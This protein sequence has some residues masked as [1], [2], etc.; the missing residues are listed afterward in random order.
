MKSKI[1][2][3]VEHTDQYPAFQKY[4]EAYLERQ[5]IILDLGY[6]IYVL[7]T[8]DK[9]RVKSIKKF[10]LLKQWY[11]DHQDLLKN[12]SPDSLKETVYEKF[13]VSMSYNVDKY[14]DLIIHPEE[15]GFKIDEKCIPKFS[16]EQFYVICNFIRQTALT[17]YEFKKAF[18][19]LTKNKPIYSIITFISST[20]VSWYKPKRDLGFFY[21]IYKQPLYIPCE[22]YARVVKQLSPSFD[23][24]N[25]LI[26][27]QVKECL[28]RELNQVEEAIITLHDIPIIEDGWKPLP[29]MIL[30][31]FILEDT[32]VKMFKIT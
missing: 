10:N 32:K 12:I 30:E 14:F 8:I 22:F 7:N 1:L 9:M 3:R 15:N 4:F 16:H 5:Y 31:C 6:V 18:K 25:Q 2:V 19:S 28:Q 11:Q 20:Q 13:C 26:T 24:A 17:D 23:E 29:L 21:T 27:N